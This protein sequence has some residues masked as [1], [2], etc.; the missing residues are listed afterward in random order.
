M[1]TPTIEISGRCEA[2]FNGVREQFERNFSERGDVGAALT[3]TID[4]ETVVDLC[5]G[6]RDKARTQAWTPDLLV[7]VYSTTKGWLAAAMN[8]LVEAGELDLESAV[9]RYW[10]EFGTHGKDAVLVRHLLT[11]EA[12]LPTTSID[13]PDEAVYEP[14]TMARALEQS[15]L[16]W[17]PGTRQ[18]YHAATFGWL[19]GELLRRVTGMS[20][21]TFVRERIAG[22]LGADIFIGL[23]ESEDGRTAEMLTP[24]APPDMAASPMQRLLA[25]PTSMT[26]RTFSNPPRPPKVANTRRWRGAEIPSSNGHAS[27][28][29]LARFYTALALGGAVD[30]VRL[31]GEAAVANAARERVNSEDAIL[32]MRTRRSLGFMLPV[33]EL[34]DPRGPGAF[35]HAGMGGSLGFADPDQR[36]GFGYVMN[37]MGPTVDLRARSLG[38]ALYAALAR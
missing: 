3:I 10:P 16:Y 29:G 28:R 27:A 25:D 38:K 36:L 14:A 4:G 11:H 26:A 19:N 35:G 24:V 22:P 37:Q 15:T 5:G 33:P 8:M 18:G 21:G 6:Y 34:G 7:N 17:V 20:A 12:G 2:R 32:G 9:V 30:G 13:V 31:L 1:A 23:P